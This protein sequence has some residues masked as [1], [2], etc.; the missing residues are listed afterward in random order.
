MDTNIE[1]IINRAYAR[2][3]QRKVTTIC[4]DPRQCFARK[5]ASTGLPVCAILTDTYEHAGKQCPF[6]KPDREVTNGKQYPY[7][8]T[9]GERMSGKKAG[10]L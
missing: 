10:V 6:C 2:I 4:S 1:K 8:K 9:Y 3:T 7:D 5:T